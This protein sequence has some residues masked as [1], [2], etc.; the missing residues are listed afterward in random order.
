V[1]RLLA[2]ALR[3]AKGYVKSATLQERDGAFAR[4]AWD[5]CL[6]FGRTDN[7]ATIWLAHA[8]LHRAF[9]AKP[10]R[11][12]RNQVIMRGT[13]P[14]VSDVMIFI[15]GGQGP[16]ARREVL[17]NRI[18]ISTVGSGQEGNLVGD[19][20]DMCPRI[21]H[22]HLIGIFWRLGLPDS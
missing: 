15:L 13:L 22:L 16:N 10:N 18:Q 11:T 2:R 12:L 7:T 17:N 8:S 19:F 9:K 6:S 3:E 21:G 14:V 20:S 4:E 1:R 5:T